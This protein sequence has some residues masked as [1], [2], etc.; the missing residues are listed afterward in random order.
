MYGV[1]VLGV[2]AVHRVLQTLGIRV[3]VRSVMR[4]VGGTGRLGVG[5]DVAGLRTALG[6]HARTIRRIR[7]GLGPCGPAA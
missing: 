4:D 7:P 5:R 2:P 6:A 1:L 3:Q